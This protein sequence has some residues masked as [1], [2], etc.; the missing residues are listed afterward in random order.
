MDNTI[1]K[2]DQLFRLQ[3]YQHLVDFGKK[4]LQQYPDFDQVHFYLAVAYFHLKKFD[5]CLRHSKEAVRLNPL[6]PTYLSTLAAAQ[7]QTNQW[8]EANQSASRA[9]SIHPVH[10]HSLIV[11]AQL[12]I[13]KT[14]WV[15]ALPYINRALAIDPLEKR[16]L[17]LKAGVEGMLGN[18]KEAEAARQSLLTHYPDDAQT[19][20]M[21]GFGAFLGQD[22]DASQTHLKEARR[23]RPDN[24]AGQRMVQSAK[25][26]KAY[27]QNSE[28]YGQLFSYG[29]LGLIGLGIYLSFR[30]QWVETGWYCLLLNISL[31][32]PAQIRMLKAWYREIRPVPRQATALQPPL[33]RISLWISIALLLI[34]IGMS[35][36][37]LIFSY[38]HQWAVGASFLLF[39][40]GIVHHVGILHLIRRLSSIYVAYLI[41]MLSLT[42]LFL[43]A[44]PWPIWMGIGMA[45]HQFLYPIINGYIYKAN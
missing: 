43:L 30:S 1:P 10:I 19:H 39:W 8:K 36:Y 16:S 41:L 27:E 38:D 3:K 23:I 21:A 34:G 45:I 14:K 6:E 12:R 18:H 17:S 4:A 7:F 5:E 33:F 29:F 35:I 37:V 11:M 28:F 32:I 15:E 31:L 25:K 26:L 24:I 22:F 13:K 44:Y 20:R 42:I 2:L 40:S 9:L